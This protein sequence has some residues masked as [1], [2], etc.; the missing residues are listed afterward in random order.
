MKKI[1]SFAIA[2][3][4]VTISYGQIFSTGQTLKAGTMSLG[5]EPTIIGN[6]FGFYMH[7]GYGLS[8][9]SDLGIKL[10]FGN[11]NAYF[12]GN[13]EWALLSK[14]PFLSVTTGAHYNGN[15]G[16]DGG[17]TLTFPVSRIFL[18]TGIDANLNFWSADVDGDGDT[19]LQTNVPLW[20]PFGLEVYLK[21]HMSI[22]VEA[23]VGI[24][25]A[26]TIVGGGLCIYF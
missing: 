21:D 20:L 1:L 19:E 14:N 9:G 22:I 7:G 6:N 10:G 26:S 25:N 23:E 13:V 17:A 15:F 4:F 18:S 24:N 11:G 5:L 8:A 3:L 12:E 2:M 16:F